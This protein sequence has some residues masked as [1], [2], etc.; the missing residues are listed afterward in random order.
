MKE[1]EVEV[2]LH[3]EVALYFKGQC[4]K[5]AIVLSMKYDYLT[6]ELRHSEQMA[7][8]NILAFGISVWIDM[9]E[10]QP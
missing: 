7:I 4:I 10:E 9:K 8:E 6:K 3:S 5:H 2:S 1:G